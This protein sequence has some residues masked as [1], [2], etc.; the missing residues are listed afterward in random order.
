MLVINSLIDLLGHEIVRIM[1]ERV[2]SSVL[3]ECQSL[4]RRH[5]N[6]HVNRSPILACHLLTP[7]CTHLLAF[8]N[9][10]TG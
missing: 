9:L 6:R 4:S 3:L 5:V 1:Q 7:V 10:L 8:V 2:R